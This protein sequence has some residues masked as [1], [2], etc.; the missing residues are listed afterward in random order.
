MNSKW[1]LSCMFFISQPR[2]VRYVYQNSSGYL[3][4]SWQ[5]IWVTKKYFSYTTQIQWCMSPKQ[6][7]Y[8]SGPQTGNWAYFSLD[9]YQSVWDGGQSDAQADSEQPHLDV[10]LPC[11]SSSAW[12]QRE[13]RG[14]SHHYPLSPRRSPQCQSSSSLSPAHAAFPPLVF[15]P[16]WWLKCEMA[17]WST[18][19]RRYDI[20]NH[21]SLASLNW[22]AYNVAKQTTHLLLP[23]SGSGSRWYVI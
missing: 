14:P 12:G 10:P 7:K 6:D 23:Y 5:S 16:S 9:R 3:S 13:L 1:K 8:L 4:G 11:S 19:R 20:S 15:V 21:S 2:S 17:G 18:C 22:P